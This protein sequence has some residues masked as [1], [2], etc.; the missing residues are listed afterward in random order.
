MKTELASLSLLSLKSLL[1]LRSL[2]SSLLREA[3]P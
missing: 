3:T 1:S 2:V